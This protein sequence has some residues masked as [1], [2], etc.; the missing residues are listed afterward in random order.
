MDHFLDGRELH[1]RM[2]RRFKTNFILSPRDCLWQG[3]FHYNPQRPLCP[4]LPYFKIGR[5]KKKKFNQL[6]T[7]ERQSHFTAM[8]HTVAISITQQLLQSMH[9]GIKI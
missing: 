7:Q 9:T 2:L 5:K 3:F 6:M 8:S 1:P 4:A